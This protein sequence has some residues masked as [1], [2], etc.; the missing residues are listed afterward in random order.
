MV[1]DG[2]G[3]GVGSGFFGLLGPAV[4]FEGV[5]GFQD[6]SG[7]S[8]ST[9]VTASFGII[10]SLMSSLGILTGPEEV[11]LIG[12]VTVLNGALLSSQATSS[13]STVFPLS[14]PPT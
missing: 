4:G 12:D 8:S 10:P 6:G 1:V 2:F 7:S 13:A 3:V 9:G 5:K 14:N 11:V